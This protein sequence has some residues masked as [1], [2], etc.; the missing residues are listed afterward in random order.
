V[1]RAPTRCR[2]PGTR[3]S[4]A[5]PA[6]ASG[7][8]LVKALDLASEIAGS[9]LGKLGLDQMVPQWR[10]AELARYGMSARSAQLKKYPVSRRLATLVA[11]VQRLETK[12][13][14][15][16]LELL[17]LL[18]VTELL[19][20]AHREADKQTIRRHPTLGKA[21]VRLALAVE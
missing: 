15:D 12:T 3:V 11:T 6:K 14:D 20:R 18:M 13:I 10:L 17:D 9:G 21:S 5:G 1:T 8:G 7:P 16:S 2:W 4:L 19:S